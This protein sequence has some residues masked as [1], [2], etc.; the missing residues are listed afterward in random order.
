MSL[1]N[2]IAAQHSAWIQKEA[3]ELPSDLSNRVNIAAAM[4][5]AHQCFVSWLWNWE[6]EHVYKPGDMR[7]KHH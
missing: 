1:G 3:E 2:H 7:Y 5:Y 6:L 4:D